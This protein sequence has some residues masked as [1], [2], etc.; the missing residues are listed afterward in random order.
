[1]IGLDEI[2][3]AIGE[4]VDA[5]VAADEAGVSDADLMWSVIR[6]ADVDPEALVNAA[7]GWARMASGHLGSIPGANGEGFISGF[8]VA[9]RLLAARADA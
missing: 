1:M 4:H 7:S 2:A 3:T 8:L 5:M 6:G 9:C